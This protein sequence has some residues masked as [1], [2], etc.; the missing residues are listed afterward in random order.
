MQ[1]S[2]GDRIV[3]QGHRVGEPERDCEVLEVHGPDGHAPFLVRWGDTGHESLFF[4]GSDA[5]VQHFEHA[6]A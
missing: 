2:V 4:P 5:T 6:R 1:A 3:I